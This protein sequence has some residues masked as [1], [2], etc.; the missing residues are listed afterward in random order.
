MVVLPVV[1]GA[2]LLGFVRQL[3]PWLRHNVGPGTVALFALATALLGGFSLVPTY[4]LEIVA[5]WAFGPVVGLVAAV[6]GLTAAALVSFGLSK[7]IVREHVLRGMRDNARCEAVR[8]AMVGS[9]AGRTV[10]IVALVRLAPV[11]PFGAANL[12]LASAGCLAGAF[13]LGS[14]LGTLPRTAVVVYMASRMAELSFE[15]Q[16]GVFVGSVVLTVV[17]V[18]VLGMVAKRALAR[19]TSH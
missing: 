17:V 12:L 9:G 5:G 7:V 4:A 1:G 8:R 14:V 10:L 3:A 11:V 6:T 19:V 13:A 15:R 18:A 2:L 16:P